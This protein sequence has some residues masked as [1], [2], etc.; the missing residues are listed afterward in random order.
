MPAAASAGFGVTTGGAAVVQFAIQPGDINGDGRT[1]DLDYFAAWRN[2]Q[3]REGNFRGDLNADGKWNLADIDLV[4]GNYQ[5][6]NPG[7]PTPTGKKGGALAPWL[8]LAPLASLAFSTS[9]PDSGEDILNPNTG[10]SLAVSA[11]D[12]SVTAKVELSSDQP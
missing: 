3:N 10:D 6:I 12:L 11:P 4:R 1:N 7:A 5:T 2:N 8:S 9:E